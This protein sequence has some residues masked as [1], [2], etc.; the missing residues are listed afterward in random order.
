[1]VVTLSIL[2]ILTA[3]LLSAGLHLLLP[4]LLRLL[5]ITSLLIT[6]LATA[7]LGHL[8]IIDVD[9][10]NGVIDTISIVV[11]RHLHPTFGLDTNAC[12][13]IAT[14]LALAIGAIPLVLAIFLLAPLLH[15]ALSHLAFLPFTTIRLSAAVLLLTPL[16]AFLA[17]LAFLALAGFGG[18]ALLAVLSLR[19]LL[20]V[21]LLIVAIILLG[22]RRRGHATDQEAGEQ[23]SS[24]GC[25]CHTHYLLLL[26]ETVR[27]TE[28]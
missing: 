13:I 27:K 20:A 16:L 9:G 10:L 4:S 25:L 2:A 6:S 11:H 3:L 23:S 18:T 15:V 12:L 5:L 7:L 19:R 28:T 21:T 14:S 8:Q 17:F 22:K 24:N 1:L 26:R